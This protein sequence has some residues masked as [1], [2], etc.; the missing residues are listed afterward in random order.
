[1]FDLQYHAVPLPC[2]YHVILQLLKATAGAR[3]GMC[4]ITLAV[5]RRPLGDLSRFGLFRLPRGLSRRTRHCRR[6]AGAQHVMCE[7]ARHGTA[8]ARHGICVIALKLLE[9]FPRNCRP[10]W[11][12]RFVLLTFFLGFR[13]VTSFPNRRFFALR[14]IFDSWSKA[15]HNDMCTCVFM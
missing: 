5:S 1:M 11:E 8:G 13:L 10:G 12:A 7:L 14:L 4:Q 2:S 9:R 15:T 6:T 3:H